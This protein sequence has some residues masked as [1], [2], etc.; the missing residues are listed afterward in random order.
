MKE[1]LML[2]YEISTVL[3]PC[4]LVYA[5]LRKRSAPAQRGR[6][7]LLMLFALYF[8]GV[9]IVT[10]AGTVYDLKRMVE[11]DIPTVQVNF[12][13]FSE[14]IDPLGYALNVVMLVPFG[15]LAP[16]IWPRLDKLWR[17]VLAGFSFSLMIELSQ[18]VN[19]RSSD[20]DD[21]LLNTL[22]AALG[23]AAYR[24]FARLFRWK[25]GQPAGGAWESAVY[26]GSMFL[27]WF[28]L[29]NGLGAAALLY[30]F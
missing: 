30:G 23:F 11:L 20:V 7:L 24:L 25:T 1:L 16:L 6:T 22:G 3:L 10:G 29:F 15:F 4:A 2:C 27:G 26:I 17:I 18:L 13:P 5:L 28:F 21:L 19:Y 9:C 8:A 14:D 12:L